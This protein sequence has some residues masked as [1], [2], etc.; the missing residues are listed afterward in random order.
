MSFPLNFDTA[1]RRPPFQTATMKSAAPPIGGVYPPRNR[2][3]SDYLRQ[4]AQKAGT[5]ECCRSQPSAEV[6][7]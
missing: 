1:I 6:V 4:L 3:D 2:G 7:T 5:P